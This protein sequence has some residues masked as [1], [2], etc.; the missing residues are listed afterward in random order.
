M[1]IQVTDLGNRRIRV[2]TVEFDRECELNRLPTA[3]ERE[4]IRW[5]LEEFSAFPFGGELQRAAQTEELLQSLGREL[6]QPILQVPEIS[7]ILKDPD[8]ELR[9]VAFVFCSKDASFLAIPWELAFS[10]DLND[11]LAGRGVMF[12]RSHQSPRNQSS[13]NLQT[14]VRVLLIISRP[15]RTGEIGVDVVAASL[16][17]LREA[18]SGRIVIDVL[19]PPSLNALQD[20]LRNEDYDV[21]H[22]DGHGVFADFDDDPSRNGEGFLLFE[23][24]D[25]QPGLVTAQDLLATCK[26]KDQKPAFVLN[27]CQSAF[28]GNPISSVAM[29]LLEGGINDVVAMSHSIGVSA[30][31]V[32][33]KTLYIALTEGCDLY[34]AVAVGR[35]KLFHRRQERRGLQDWFVPVLYSRSIDLDASFC[36]S[37]VAVPDKLEATKSWERLFGRGEQFLKTERLLASGEP[38]VLLAGVIGS[39]KSEFCQ[40]F[41]EWFVA[42]GGASDY[43][44]LDLHKCQTLMEAQ[45]LTQ[46]SLNA[47]RASN[48]SVH[49]AA[50]AESRRFDPLIVWDHAEN[51]LREHD[52]VSLRQKLN[53]GFRYVVVASGI[54]EQRSRSHLVMLHDLT[55]AEAGRRIQAEV[56]HGILRPIVEQERIFNESISVA[57]WHSRALDL[58][59]QQ[60]PSAD[61]DQAVES[62]RG[63]V[64]TG[65]EWFF[66]ARVDEAYR[67]LSPL[68][69]NAMAL[70][71]AHGHR[72]IVALLHVFAD[73][74]RL[75]G[76]VGKSVDIPVSSEQWQEVVRE[77]ASYGLISGPDS[78]GIIDIPPLTRIRLRQ[79]LV[80]L[81][82]G[83][84]RVVDALRHAMV[85]YYYALAHQFLSEPSQN[86][87]QF[88][89]IEEPTIILAIRH[90]ILQKKFYEAKLLTRLFFD[91][92]QRVGAWTM[93]PMF[94]EEISAI[95]EPDFPATDDELL[96]WSEL[97]THMASH[98]AMKGNHIQAKEIYG[99][100][101]D[102]LS[103]RREA[104]FLR[105]VFNSEI[106]LATL[107]ARMG[108]G[109]LALRHLEHADNI[110]REFPSR[111]TETRC[112]EVRRVLARSR[113]GHYVQMQPDSSN[114]E[115]LSAD[116]NDPLDYEAAGRD[117]MDREDFEAAHNY[118]ARAVVLWSN[119]FGDKSEKD[120]ARGLMADA[121]V[122]LGRLNEALTIYR[123]L[124]HRHRQ[125]GDINNSANTA[126]LIGQVLEQLGQL[127]E[128]RNWCNDALTVMTQLGLHLNSG[129]V[130][131]ELAIVQFKLAIE[132]VDQRNTGLAEAKD[133]ARQAITTYE[134]IDSPRHAASSMVLLGQMELLDGAFQ[135]GQATLRKARELGTRMPAKV[136]DENLPILLSQAEMLCGESENA[137]PLLAEYSHL[138]AGQS[139]HP[140]FRQLLVLASADIGLKR[141]R[142]L[143]LRSNGDAS[144]LEELQAIP[145]DDVPNA[146]EFLTAS[147]AAWKKSGGTVVTM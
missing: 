2:R 90:A 13:Q 53:G 112:N 103:G 54:P 34:S 19:R 47:I 84:V 133:Y 146:R 57:E 17:K 37:D 74:D 92:W 105:E 143:W 52:P 63:G 98:S 77:A 83:D 111:F 124:A 100:T 96:F 114:Q 82:D 15:K 18:S 33:V 72:I 97:N 125:T 7:A 130:L 107:E 126:L 67:R 6:F 58:M 21:I 144:V 131:H 10:D 12:V 120:K 60:Y 122:K 145:P 117:A 26:H 49:A 147:F 66:D 16:A 23:R 55:N 128:A 8:T 30:V 56:D 71:G 11:F 87:Q 41:A 94:M 89:N 115:E 132:S 32:F 123:E 138:Q 79:G 116:S 14:P 73:G 69:Q 88:A 95:C 75:E 137:V 45:E 127:E 136:L 42:S 36:G 20:R 9:N 39:G 106:E 99:E 68:S 3:D 139:V 31:E 46:Q 38:L 109:E 43:V 27:A 86:S 140:E 129:H 85:D 101:I 51:L 108:A 48:S 5:Y 65:D 110:A 1:Q 64:S 119:K 4:V 40:S 29:R 81:A 61:L 28:H 50:G 59:I 141:F 76:E 142:T 78:N 121:L 80:E 93:T 70:L 62:L 24:G 134:K 135:E 25:A 102:R 104:E 118:F 44:L 113:G 22:F 35:E 91:S